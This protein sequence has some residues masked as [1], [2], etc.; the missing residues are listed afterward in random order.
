MTER[1]ESEE[2]T[3]MPRSAQ[4]DGTG[5]GARR[6]TMRL[7][8][9]DRVA[10]LLSIQRA[11]WEQV[12]PNLRGVT[13]AIHNGQAVTARFLYE[14]SIGDVERECTSLAETHFI[15]DMPHDVPVTFYPIE[16][17]TREL[18]PG[19]EWVYLRRESDD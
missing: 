16:H 2:R 8:A 5:R 10:M 3:V 14:D 6:A 12:T 17:A 18:L 11:L 15:A 4:P 1:E 13:V 9:V 19:E 7:M